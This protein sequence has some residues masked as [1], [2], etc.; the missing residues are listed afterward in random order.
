M[1]E[2]DI[3]QSANEFVSALINTL[4]NGTVQEVVEKNFDDALEI[5]RISYPLQLDEVPPELAA[6]LK[7]LAKIVK[8]TSM[9]TR[10]DLK[11]AFP[12]SHFSGTDNPLM[13][14]YKSYY[15]VIANHT[16][17]IENAP[18]TKD[19]L[20]KAMADHGYT[21]ENIDDFLKRMWD[22]HAHLMSLP[23]IAETYKEV[24]DYSDYNSGKPNN[25]SL[26]NAQRKIEHMMEGQLVEKI[27]MENLTL[28]D[29]T[30]VSKEATD[31]LFLE[32]CLS[33]LSPE[34]REL[35][36]RYADG[37][38]LTA[39]AKDYGYANA[40]GV[41]KRIERIKKQILEKFSA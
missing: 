22:I 38:T 32:E 36:T 8:D 23:Q 27:S 35:L 6:R 16:M 24:P 41:K 5:E 40:S 34:D 11:L 9:D 13:L 31:R 18:E 28:E 7:D 3:Q 26:Q 1:N 33:S 37:E 39:L 10:H 2:K 20:I 19:A 12:P 29:S 17:L 30:D 4:G 15:N 25:Y 21:E 14:F